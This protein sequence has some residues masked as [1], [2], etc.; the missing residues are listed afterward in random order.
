MSGA[1]MCADCL[2]SCVYMG[3]APMDACTLARSIAVLDRNIPKTPVSIVGRDDIYAVQ[4]W[5]D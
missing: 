3:F 4:S 2:P 1:G 5:T